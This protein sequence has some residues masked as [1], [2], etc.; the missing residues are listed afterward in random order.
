M[1]SSNGTDRKCSDRVANNEDY[2]LDEE[3]SMPLPT[4]SDHESADWNRKLLNFLQVAEQNRPRLLRMAERLT[5][6]RED[7][8]DVLQHSLL[9]AWLN[10][11]QF[12]EEAKMSTWLGTIVQNSA[13]EYLRRRRGFTFISVDPYSQDDRAVV[14]D[15]TDP[16]KNPEEYRQ[17]METEE[18]LY[19]EIDKLVPYC[20]SVVQ[21]CVLREIPQ[22][23]VARSLN[24]SVAT[25]K[26]RM[27]R[28]KQLLQKAVRQQYGVGDVCAT[29]ESTME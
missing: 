16:A 21:M 28:S 22:R 24:V 12:R 9:R 20:R 1:R 18:I 11:S 29:M 4:A 23:E 10:L 26:S 7:A 2:L 5:H 15:I 13:R 19:K 6:C 25:I 27:F 3:K 8:E 14:R 17:R